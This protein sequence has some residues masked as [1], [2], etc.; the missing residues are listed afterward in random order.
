MLACFSLEVEKQDEALE[1]MLRTVGTWR[2][3]A[4]LDWPCTELK[5]GDKYV[6]A[7]AQPVGAVNL[8]T[9]CRPGCSPYMWATFAPVRSKDDE[10]LED[11]TGVKG[12]EWL[13]KE[14]AE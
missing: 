6:M 14:A 8:Y 3:G 5:L 9:G 13:L 4:K 7:G 1:A 11:T 10:Y 2:P 12:Q